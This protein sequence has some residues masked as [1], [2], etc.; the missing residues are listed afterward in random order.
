VQVATKYAP[1]RCTPVAAAHPL[2]LRR[3][4]SN[5]CGCHKY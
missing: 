2:C 5:S 3:L 4:A 1:A